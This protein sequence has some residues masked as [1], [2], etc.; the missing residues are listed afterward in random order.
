MLAK[1]SIHAVSTKD[2]KHLIELCQ[3]QHF[4]YIFLDTEYDRENCLSISKE[5]DQ[6]A[7]DRGSKRNV[8]IALVE[9]LN[10]ELIDLCISSGM[11][12]YLNKPIAFS[13]LKQITN[14][15]FKVVD[16]IINK[17]KA[18]SSTAFVDKDD[19]PM[20][21]FN[22]TKDK[23]VPLVWTQ[24]CFKALK[25]AGVETAMHTIE[26]AGHLEAAQDKEALTKAYAFL[27]SHL[28]A[29]KRAVAP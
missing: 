10:P 4:D 16:T 20:F 23:L 21:F 11:D 2:K 25:D 13:D 17:F 15:E 8:F 29:E 24:G 26:G 7:N 12:T 1:L 19:P 18:A 3:D 9:N 5:L 14:Q 28:T 27:V 6:L 22:G